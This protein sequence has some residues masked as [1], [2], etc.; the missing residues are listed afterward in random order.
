M[1]KRIMHMTWKCGWI[2]AIAMVFLPCYAEA[3]PLKLLKNRMIAAM[4][5]L[6]RYEKLPPFDPHRKSFTCMY[7]DQVV[8]P[9]DPQAET[10]YQQA[11]ALDDP[12]IYYKKRDYTK[13]YELYQ[14]AAERHHWKAMLNLAS[15]ILSGYS[16]PEHNPEVA[17]R[18]V[19]KAMLLG[20]PDAYDR[21]GVYHQNGLIKGG[22]ATTAYAFFQRA[23][24]MGSPA[25]MTLFG[26]KLGGTYDYPAEGFWGNRVIAIQMLECAV[27]QG[28][29]A[30]AYELSLQYRMPFTPESK[31][32]A[33]EVLQ[34]GVR[35][36]CEKCASNLYVEFNGFMLSSGENL[37]GRVDNARAERYA[38]LA[39]ALEHYGGRLKLPNIDKI[40]PLPP[41][42]L[43]KWD[44][45]KQTL[46]DAAKTVAPPAERPR[47]ADRQG[48]EHLPEG[49]AVLSLAHS[50]YFVS[51][52]RAVPES[53]YWIALYG[54][55]RMPK[56][57]LRFARGDFPERYRAG[58]RFEASRIAWLEREFTQWHFLGEAKRLPP[59]RETFI[60]R[61]V[62]MRMMRRVP[63][64]DELPPCHGFQRCPAAGIWEGRV[65]PA[66]PMA[67]LFNRWE[68]QTYVEEGQPFPE[69]RAKF[70][71]IQPEHV[72]WTYRGSPNPAIGVPG[73]RRI[74]L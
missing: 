34:E 52:D 2:V 42:S 17:I 72:R 73:I 61:L 63:A 54:L 47:G 25:A 59:Q 1:I 26:D 24:D 66:H 30:A 29:G 71:D 58:E 10:W 19:E 64:A 35:L 40:V 12:D 70:I 56:E 65:V 74:A 51:G 8:P 55:S 41:A 38:V 53:G 4:S 6:P 36:G 11:V 27:A 69:P 9:L 31:R 60:A 49:H 62:E 15:L 13:I 32:R 20:V 48:R 28:Y 3:G 45:N 22:S 21:M 5:D 50:P 7:Q 57:K 44:G 68:Q 67:T 18:W 23:A 46:I 14:Q 39:D 33:L 37:S 16:V 43:P